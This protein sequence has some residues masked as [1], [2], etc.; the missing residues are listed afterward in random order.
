M[1]STS[2]TILSYIRFSSFILPFSSLVF[3]FFF[4]NDTAPTEI[5]PLPLHDALPISSALK[6]PRGFFRSAPGRCPPARRDE[7]VDFHA[8][9]RHRALLAEPGEVP[10]V[11]CLGA[12]ERRGSAPG[13]IGRAHV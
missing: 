6:R 12:S 7:V 10:A 4:F 9:P 13:E 3:F 11:P 8:G 1:Y 5:S 2:F